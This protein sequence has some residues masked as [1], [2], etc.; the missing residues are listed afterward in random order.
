MPA[1]RAQPRKSKPLSGKLVLVTRA[2]EQAEGLSR[3]LRAQGARVIEV[4]LIEIRRPGSWQ[5][6]DVALENLQKYQW[7]ILTSVNGVEALF[8]R[9]RT[10]GVTRACLYHLKTVAIGPA[11]RAAIEAKGLPVEVTPKQYVAEA[12]VNML[13]KRVQ[14]KRVLLVRAAVARD[15]IPRELR[16]AGAW[17]DVVSAYETRLPGA[18]RAS[19]R[20]VLSSSARPDVITFTS[21]STVHNFARV[22]GHLMHTG[23]LDRIAMA[24]VGPVT[25][26]T[27]REY[28]MHPAVEAR[29]Y[30]MAGLTKGIMSWGRKQKPS[31]S[32]KH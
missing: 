19:L 4:P 14:G 24:S 13:R 21:S 26:A 7:L 1:G 16:R 6:L 25:S 5:K 15:V 2:K 18:S 28:G 10:L 32:S 12:V 17:V 11:T 8:G 23:H 30:T 22:A 20:S 31:K 29:E 3:L 27:L 9:M